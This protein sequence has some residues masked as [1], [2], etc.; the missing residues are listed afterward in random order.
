MTAAPDL[1]QARA[2]PVPQQ[3]RAVPVPQPVQE[4]PVPEHLVRAHPAPA[5]PVVLGRRLA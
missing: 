4:L 5:V 2:V 1:Q 3:V